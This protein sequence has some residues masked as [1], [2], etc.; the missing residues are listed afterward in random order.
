MDPHTLSLVTTLLFV[1]TA[2]VAG[3]FFA[4]ALKIPMLLGYIIM[5]FVFGN[6][7]PR[8]TDTQFLHLISDVGVTL[9][10]F[11][12]GVEFSFHRLRHVLRTVFWAAFFQIVL[13]TTLLFCVLFGLLGMLFLPALFLSIAGALSSTVVVVKILFEKG[14][15][16]T[17]PGEILTAWLVIQDLAVIPIMILLPGLVS[18]YLSGS[19]TVVG[20]TTVIFFQLLKAAAA[21][22]LVLFFGK[23][24]V[25][26]I[27]K[28]VAKLGS[29][30]VYLITT[31]GIVFISA[32]S[33]YAFGLSAGLGAFIAGLMIAETSQ[34][35]MVFSEVRPLR[36]IFSTIF[37]VSLGMSI[38]IATI[39]L[40][41]PMVIGMTALIVV[42]KF[43]VVFLLS[44]FLGYHP[45]TAWLV[46]LGLLPMSEFGFIL[47]REG[48]ISGALSS[49]DFILLI[50]LVVGTIAV[51][52]PFLF[53]GQTL[54]YRLKKLL[55][56]K[57]FLFG[58]KTNLKMEKNEELPLKDHVVICG[59]GRVGKYVGR[60][61]EM[62]GIPLVV[63]DYNH[64]IVT[65]VKEKGITVVYGDPADR[66]VLDKAQVDYAKAIVIAIPDLHSQELIIGHAL[67][68][69][70]N[71]Q[72]ICRTHHEEDQTR[73][74][75]LGVQIIVQPEFEAS[76]S[77]IHR[78]LPEYG[79]VSDDLSG[80]ISRLKIEHGVG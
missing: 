52:S 18:L 33:L 66:D 32:L 67:T 51:S 40:L 64:T 79:V 71:I 60:A 7:L 38:P 20:A 35:H 78:L 41:W 55:G 68:L 65:K 8:F 46:G 54:Y 28:N 72:I 30:E 73:L 45:K 3:G 17:M 39:A 22:F 27:L 59:Y 10:L 24:G 61:L 69:N 47:A 77:I 74:K 62:A 1:F 31:I 42:L 48:L 6:I 25:P 9:L 14:E 56:E 2:A 49:Q 36:D 37:F 26:F 21:I 12:L 53:H 19:P 4:H 75:T 80:K 11:T 44:R 50:S 13:V 16:D 63:V 23:T 70:K 43:V 76:L 57:I 5:G 58:R 15:L 29:R 34:N